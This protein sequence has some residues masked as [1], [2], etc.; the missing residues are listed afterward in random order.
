MVTK[1]ELEKMLRPHLAFVLK[2]RPPVMKRGA[3]KPREPQ[4]RGPDMARAGRAVAKEIAPGRLPFKATAEYLVGHANAGVRFAGAFALAALPLREWR[5]HVALAERLAD[6]ENWEVR[7]AAV[8]A[9]RPLLEHDYGRAVKLLRRWATGGNVNLQRAAALAVMVAQRRPWPGPVADIF[10][11][12]AP[13]MAV[14]AEYVRKNLGPFAIGSSIGRHYPEETLSFLRKMMKAG[15]EQTR[16]NVAMAFNQSFG[17]HN[18][19]LAL[20][21]LTKLAADESKY[22]RTAAASSLRNIGRRHPRLVKPLLKK[23][24]K[25]AKRQEVAARVAKFLK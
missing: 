7:E 12:L 21:F 19:E 1:A 5:W 4:P 6:D 10:D 18:P 8:S 13:L 17:V 9:F 11:V 22:V 3:P 24:E 25:E 16:W 2:Y 20:P 23:W 14:R 15:D